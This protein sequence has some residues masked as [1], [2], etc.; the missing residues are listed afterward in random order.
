M[1]VT[2]SDVPSKRPRLTATATLS[3]RLHVAE[4]NE[5]FSA[6]FAQHDVHQPQADD[7]HGGTPHRLRIRM[8][9]F[10]PSL[11]GS[12]RLHQAAVLFRHEHAGV[13]QQR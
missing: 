8:E 10:P 11:K 9:L 1:S 12:A 6:N 13:G 7:L 4:I 3:E 2:V 5:L